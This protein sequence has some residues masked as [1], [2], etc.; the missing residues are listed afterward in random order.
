MG[1]KKALETDR[2]MRL[3]ESISKLQVASEARLRKVMAGV[4]GLGFGVADP[5]LR[6]SL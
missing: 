2:K 1:R 4:T 6:K 5:I 3:K